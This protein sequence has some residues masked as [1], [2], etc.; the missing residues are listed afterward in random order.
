MSFATRRHLL[1]LTTTSLIAVGLLA[2][3]ARSPDTAHAQAAKAA[4]AVPVTAATVGAM[5]V[6]VYLTG[7]GTVTPL[8]DVTVRS[9]VDGQITGIHFKEG[10]QV[11]E[12]DALVDIDRRAFQA[13]ADQAAARLAQ[14]QATLANARLELTRHER[15]AEV[16]ATSTQ[17]LEA[18]RARVDELVAQVRG[19]RA[20]VANA[21]V[22]V[23]YTTVRAPIS[24]RVGF[25]L[26]DQGNIVRANDTPILTLVTTAPIT[27]MYAQ[28]QN[29]LPDIQAAMRGGKVE[30]V[31]LN[32]DG[33]RVLSRGHLE[34]IGNRVDVNSGVIRLKGS[35]ANADG[36]LWPGQSVMIRTVVD[37]LRDVLA[38]P[39]DA[40]QTGPNGHFVYV[41]GAG[42][43]VAPRP[44]RLGPRV[45][46][47]AVIASGLKSGE[48]V[49]VQGQYRLQDGARVAATLL[50]PPAAPL[51]ADTTADV[52]HAL[53]AGSGSLTL[54]A[55]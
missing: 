27:V 36:A 41:I 8:Y 44:V 6:P 21:R 32:T 18:Q 22:S 47:H 52:P 46:G 54:G 25:R 28:S 5:D 23:D 12:G 11:R 34:T 55:D 24:G 51:S 43:T 9:Q 48:R 30:V 7:V 26:A 39:D 31:A 49:V 29:A 15:L 35:F 33:T 14:D 17:A 16:N 40:I 19:D 53:D 50:P 10:Q 20:A 37:T 2:W 3:L 13:Q 42:D 1:A 45:L 38:V 4:P